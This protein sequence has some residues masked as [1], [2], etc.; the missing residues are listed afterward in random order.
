MVLFVC[1]F[2]HAVFLST[3][4]YFLFC[5]EDTRA[6]VRIFLFFCNP[7]CLL[8]T[9][10]L[11]H[12]CQHKHIV[13]HNCEYRARHVSELCKMN[14]LVLFCFFCLNFSM[15][16]FNFGRHVSFEYILYNVLK[17]SFKCCSF[18][19]I[20]VPLFQSHYF[21]SLPFHIYLYMFHFHA[22]SICLLSLS[23]HS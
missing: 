22:F 21:H 13:F 7:E 1:V 16:S 11:K 6:L 12:S 23:P 8:W 5:L 20:P 18:F 4:I 2:S 9:A 10:N 17:H 19:R 3:W 15:Y 14:I